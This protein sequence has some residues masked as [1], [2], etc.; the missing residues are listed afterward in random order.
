MKA[1]LLNEH[2][3]PEVLKYGE[4]PT[5]EPGTGEASQ[6]AYIFTPNVALKG[7]R[8]VNMGAC[9]NKLRPLGRGS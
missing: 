3:G 4:F 9:L 1:I 5:P 6:G 2:G 8:L 7:L